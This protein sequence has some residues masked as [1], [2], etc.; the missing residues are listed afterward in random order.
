MSHSIL[1][2]WRLGCLLT[3]ASAGGWAAT[4]SPPQWTL[5]DDVTPISHTIEITLDPRQ[6]T[7][8]GV[9]RIEVDLKAKRDTIWV[10]GHD[11]AVH[12][13]I[14]RVGDSSRKATIRLAANEFIGL[15][16]ESSIGPGRV[17]I[18]IAYTAKLS[19]T[20]KSGP[21]RRQTDGDWYAFT[22]FTPI[23]ARRAFPCFDEPRFK[24]VWDM[25]IR[26]RN[27]DKAFANSPETSTDSQVK[28]MKLVHFAPTQKIPAEVVAFAVGP[29]DVYD[30][31]RAGQRET[32]V[33]V[34]T[35]RG[36][37]EEGKTAA[38]ATRRVLPKL[39]AYTG[40]AY[41][42]DKLDHVA[43][44]EGAFGA[45]ENPGLITYLARALLL[46]PDATKEKVRSLD[47]LE[48]HELAH[49]WFG[50]LVTQSTWDDVWLSEGF[51]TWFSSEVMDEFEAP[52]NVHL[53]LEARRARIMASDDSA[54]SHPVHNPKHTRSEMDSVYDQFP[55]QKGAAIL[56]TLEG[57]LGKD[58]LRDGLRE[59]LRKYA[60]G[61]ATSSDLAAELSK[62]SGAADVRPVLDSLLD[63]KG[64]PV[65]EGKIDCEKGKATIKQP[66]DKVQ[67]I[68]IC[69]RTG[70]GAACV[71]A[72][73][74]VTEVALNGCPNWIE[75][76]SG[77]MGYFHTRYSSLSSVPPLDVLTSPERL[78][79]A[80]DL[81]WS[82]EKGA[83]EAQDVAE[84]MKT[85]EHDPEPEVA[86]AAA[87]P[88]VM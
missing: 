68:P 72:K 11:I 74:P 44:P 55:Y 57:W 21:Y 19:D 48:A 60:S 6:P 27:E 65:V 67:T 31:G 9:A 87:G 25:S 39:E 15:V 30:G 59:Y 71:V 73:S 77:G 43:L 4:D 16:P 5:P 79:L 69:Y 51:A 41:P 45:V 34:L 3:L 85:L 46:P 1:F 8:T 49:Q 10:N 14:I 37:A 40:I 33:R 81:R 88:K 12:S 32:A 28:G 50:N 20:A 75:W 17:T 86:A 61:N 84:L 29:F 66:A 22:V 56:L 36:R 63:H 13:A 53:K 80:L 7:F 82:I 18:E 64:V 26:V 76:N 23:D 62:A 42:W 54:K 58:K 47:G 70:T 83:L 24:T 38:D 35:P 78:T 52:A 2:S